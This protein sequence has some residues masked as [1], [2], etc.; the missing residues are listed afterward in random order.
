MSFS[1]NSHRRSFL[2]KMLG[3]AAAAASLPIAATR[4]AAQGASLSGPDAWLG[5]VKGT[6]RCLF[7]FPQHK[8]GV[9]LLHILNY[10]NTY[11]AAYKTVPGQVGAVG[12]FYGIGGQASIAL[13]F[14]DAMWVKYGLGEY[15]GLKDTSGKPYTR[16]VF[17]RPTKNEL[18]L[19]MQ[20]M[21]TPT[22]PGLAD[23]LPGL[24][25]ES[26]QKMGTKFLMCANALGAWCMELEARGKGKAAELEKEL[27]AN[28]LSGVTIVPA[29][30]IAIEKAQEAGVR[31]NRQ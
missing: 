1:E 7:D 16:N 2:G 21:Q 20:A 29:M 3:A 27:R 26:L 8:N 9:P 15:T 5:E 11:A 18:H 6:H 25:I 4:V 10:L 31:Y 19:L 22:I 24:G 23:A 17:H 13:G 12:T 30:V 28:L 14:S